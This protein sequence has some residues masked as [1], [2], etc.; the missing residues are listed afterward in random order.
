VIQPSV[1]PVAR[2]GRHGSALMLAAS[3]PPA[4]PRNPTTFP[5]PTRPLEQPEWAG[6]RASRT[7]PTNGLFGFT[8][9]EEGTLGPAAG[10][11]TP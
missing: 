9:A 1:A 2:N 8:T 10:M 3:Y 7:D 6:A 5:C 4:R 11:T